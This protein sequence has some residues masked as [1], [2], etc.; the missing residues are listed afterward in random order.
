VLSKEPDVPLLGSGCIMPEM[1]RP[2]SE[3]QSL[4][5]E[6]AEL[7]GQTIPQSLLLRADQVIE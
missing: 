6:L 5:K 4:E 3:R 1:P 2:R 7:P